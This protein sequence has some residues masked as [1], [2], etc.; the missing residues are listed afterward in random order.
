MDQKIFTPDFMGVGGEKT[1][2]T[3]IYKCL[4]EHP[5]ICGPQKKE[6]SYFD[7][8][9]IIG[10]DH[11]EKSEYEMHGIEKYLEYFSH[12]GK[13]VVTGEYTAQYLHD[14][15]VAPLLAKLFPNVKIL[16][17]LRNPIER[18]YSMYQGISEK[19]RTLLG[20]FEEAI[21]KEPEFIRRSM[22]AEYIGE[23]LKYFPKEHIRIVLQDDVVRDPVGTMQSLYRFLGVSD[24]FIPPSAHTKERSA[25]QKKLQTI[26][27]RVYQ[28]AF[29]RLC[30]RYAK[31]L[32]LTTYIKKLLQ[33][34]M[35]KDTMR[36]ETRERLYAM[37]KSDI[38][39]TGMLIGRDL[40]HWR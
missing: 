24:T 40:T 32:G 2:S 1:A 19:D 6:L 10:W 27:D 5:D 14:K 21:E 35:K 26:R 7:T 28:N 36:R 30:A 12:C 18:T 13:D 22:Y 4:L 29:M 37:F 39:K 23:Y 8:V 11:R 34:F 33:S 20:T 25:E 15:K 9:K 38:E 31:R 17:S 16:I 3:W